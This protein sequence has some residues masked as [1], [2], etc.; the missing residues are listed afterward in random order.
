MRLTK[1]ALEGA[2]KNVQRLWMEALA[3]DNKAEIARWGVERSRI[4]S[5][6]IS[7]DE[8]TNND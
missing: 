5:M 7:Y 4:L 2:L 8:E 3:D 1:D 6:I